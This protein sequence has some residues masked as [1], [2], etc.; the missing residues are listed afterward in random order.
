MIFA[1]ITDQYVGGTFLS[2]SL[3]YLGGNNRYFLAKKDKWIDLCADPVTNT[4]AH[5]FVANH[6]NVSTDESELLRETF[7]KLKD[8]ATD[9]FHTIYF[10]RGITEKSTIECVTYLSQH[11]DKVIIV[12]GKKYPLYHCKYE[13]RA[14]NL[15]ISSGEVTND[16]DTFFDDFVNTFFKESLEWWNQIDTVWDKREFIALNFDHYKINE[17]SSYIDFT[18]PHYYIDGLDLWMHFDQT[19]DFLLNYL[20]LKVT[21][22][23]LKNWKIVYSK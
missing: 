2:W 10:H 7:K 8:V 22:E 23:R 20:G 19:V 1:I 13:R 17:I 15:K 18:V 12:S 16:P 4:N 11:A 6:P 14:S 21:E 9:D 3:H 5:N